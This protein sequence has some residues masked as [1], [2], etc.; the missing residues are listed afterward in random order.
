[1]MPSAFFYHTDK[2]LAVNVD[3]YFQ[4]N[5]AKIDQLRIQK[6]IS[7]QRNSEPFS[8]IAFM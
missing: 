8:K 3:I 5:Y 2:K 7:L 6:L 1:M 4:E